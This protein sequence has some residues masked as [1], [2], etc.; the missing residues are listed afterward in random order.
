MTLARRRQLEQRFTRLSA[1]LYDTRVPPDVLDAEVAPYLADDITFSDPWQTGSG[2]AAYRLGLEGFH[3]LFRFRFEPAQVSVQ[4]D[5]GER[6]GRAIADGVMQLEA[7]AP[8]YTFPLRTMLVYRFS[9]DAAGEPRIHAHEEHWSVG[10]L[11][12]ALPLIGRPYAR[13]FRR[14]FAHGFL[15]VSRLARRLG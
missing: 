6:S 11:L 4:L 5:P 14:A 12:A 10:D 7:L 8:L 1:L 15:L 13:G 2:R 9:L 3:R